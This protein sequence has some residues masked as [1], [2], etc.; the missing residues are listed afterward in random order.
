MIS[1]RTP[2]VPTPLGVIRQVERQTRA[3]TE[4]RAQLATI[5][6]TNPA[7]LPHARL[8]FTLNTGWPQFSSRAS[9]YPSPY[10]EHAA[11]YASAWQTAKKP[12]RRSQSNSNSPTNGQV[13]LAKHLHHLV[14]WLW[15]GAAQRGGCTHLVSKSFTH[16][17]GS[18]PPSPPLPSSLACCPH[19]AMTQHASAN[20]L[21]SC[22]GRRDQSA[23][24]P[25]PPPPPP[26]PRCAASS[27]IPCTKLGGLRSSLAV[28]CTRQRCRQR[29]LSRFYYNNGNVGAGHSRSDAV[30]AVQCYT[31]GAACALSALRREGTRPAAPWTAGTHEDTHCARHG[32]VPRWSDSRPSYA[33]ETAHRRAWAGEP[34][35]PARLLA[36]SIG[37]VAT[38]MTFSLRGG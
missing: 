6:D 13:I 24:P 20:T 16:V 23:L 14:P 34:Y 31:D 25:L 27:G 36:A 21:C 5:G 9:Q 10:L 7:Q 37:V 33:Q 35:C 22:M 4:A 8:Q 17:G 1:T 28:V 26:P 19:A 15:R 29:A 2:F 30:T 32:H 11:A 3:A 18:A 38:S 12:R